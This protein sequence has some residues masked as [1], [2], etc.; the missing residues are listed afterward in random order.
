MYPGR[1][2]EISSTGYDL[3]GHQKISP[4][5]FADKKVSLSREE[6]L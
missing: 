6:N 4:H 1:I 5:F 2:H 3:S